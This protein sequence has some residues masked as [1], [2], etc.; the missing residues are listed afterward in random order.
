MV[1]S[2]SAI[3]KL[4]FSNLNK[5]KTKGRKFS[6]V[7]CYDYSFAKLINQS[8]IDFILVGDSLGNV[9]LGHESTIKVTLDDMIRHSAAVSRGATE[10]LIIVDMPF[11]TYGVD[12]KT[13]VDNAARLIAEGNAHAVKVEGAGCKLA[14]IERMTELGIPVIGHL[15][16]MPQQIHKTGGYKVQGKSAKS[17]DAI[18][19]ESKQL[20]S[21][22]AAMLVLEM[23]EESLTEKITSEL[24]IPTIGIG[25]GSHCDGQVL[26]LQ[27]LLGMDADFNPTFLKKYGQLS[28]TVVESI[29]TYCHEVQDGVFPSPEH[30]F[31]KK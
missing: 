27:D 4:N 15:G 8:N 2:H 11:M 19:K 5:H 16:L 1:Y 17:V 23:V 31:R 10:K 18:I 3:R 13:T 12:L 24:S 29:N 7:T 28:Q 22:G 21:A 6:M 14:E 26:V 30:S 20:E 25:A 9:I